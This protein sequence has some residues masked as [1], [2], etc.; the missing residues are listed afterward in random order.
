MK[1]GWIAYVIFA[2]FAAVLILLWGMEP[3][4]QLMA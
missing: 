3:L 4:S 1:A 2:L